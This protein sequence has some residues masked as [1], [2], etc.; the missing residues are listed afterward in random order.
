MEASSVRKKGE[1]EG[2]MTDKL[3]TGLKES[4]TSTEREK[5]E[6]NGAK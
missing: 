3:E 5:E 4:D 1:N 2:A 6:G